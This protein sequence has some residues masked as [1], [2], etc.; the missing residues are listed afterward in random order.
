MVVAVV[1]LLESTDLLVRVREGLGGYYC[2]FWGPMY[3]RD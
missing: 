3:L 1:V 2:C